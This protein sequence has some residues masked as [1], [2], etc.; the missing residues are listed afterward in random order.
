M[1]IRRTQ[2]LSASMPISSQSDIAFLLIIFFM[3]TAVFTTQ[4]GLSIFLP[5]KDAQKRTV[6][7]HDLLI[8]NLE[9]D[10][11][12]ILNDRT[13]STKEICPRIT[14]IKD[15]NPQTILL[16]KISNHCP[17]GTVV[18][19]INE[20]QRVPDLRLSLKTVGDTQ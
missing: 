3:V 16:F 5:K 8:L 11:T 20:I 1:H 4:E 19:V 14:E 6:S 12:L 7:A 18:T 10:G 2:K 17:Y 9:A 15:A 13:I